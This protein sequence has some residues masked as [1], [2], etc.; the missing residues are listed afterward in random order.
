[1]CIKGTLPSLLMFVV[2]I[3]CITLYYTMSCRP[4]SSSNGLTAITAIMTKDG[5]N[6]ADQYFPQELLNTA[7]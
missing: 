4:T 6:Y 3:L 7:R 2:C 1:M 5:I